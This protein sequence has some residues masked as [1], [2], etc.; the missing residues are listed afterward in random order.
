MRNNGT[1]CTTLLTLSRWRHGFEPR[2]GCCAAAVLLPAA[3]TALD[4]A[5][6]QVEGC[7]SCRVVHRKLGRQ[8][9]DAIRV[10]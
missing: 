6:S 1:L 4:S 2:W 5:F 3:I 10:D 8:E 9:G 7:V